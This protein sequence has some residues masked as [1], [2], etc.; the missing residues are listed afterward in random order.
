MNELNIDL[1]KYDITAPSITEMKEQFSGMV[2]TD[3]E[4]YKAVASA[5][6]V[7]RGHRTAVE[8]RRKELKA[9]SLEFGRMVDSRAKEIT[10][11]LLEIEEPLKVEKKVEDDKEAAIEA[12]KAVKEEERKAAILAKITSISDLN[13]PDIINM[14]STEIG[15]LR[16]SLIDLEIKGED[17]EE[18]SQQ[19]E[20]IKA[21]VLT[22]IQKAYDERLAFEAAAVKAKEE[23][24]RQAKVREVQE[25]REKELAKKENEIRRRAA[26]IKAE[27]D[28]ILA[29]NDEK[30][31]LEVLKKRLEDVKI[32]AEKDAKE[33]AERK[34]RERIEREEREELEAKEKAE[35]EAA[36]KARQ[37]ALK[38]DKA[39]IE[40]FIVN[41]DGVECRGLQSPEAIAA[42]S[43]FQIGLD[44]LL[45]DLKSDIENL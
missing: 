36:E 10:T 7:V 14:D 21:N 13:S 44:D 45:A 43:R 31:R 20:H 28:R 27:E 25:A 18:F 17:F 30:K 8:K 4:S 40:G 35:A 34:E 38:P 15:K 11:S 32:Q 41:I 2:I 23:E 9:E 42:L 24:E 16:D 39:R 6:S 19:A 1:V 26:E 5:I 12:E 3:K 33:K 22:V 37:E 29:E